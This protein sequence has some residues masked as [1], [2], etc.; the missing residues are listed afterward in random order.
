MNAEDV[1]AVLES[2]GWTASVV[3]RADVSDLV[4]VEAGELMKCV[5]GR[6][7]DHPAMRGPKTLGGIYALASLR[8]ITDVGGLAAI[9][10]EVRAA[11]YGPSVHGDEHAEPQSMGCGY[12][13]LW[14][15]GALDGLE[16]PSF[17]SEQGRD[18]VRAAGG[19]YE[20]L[21]GKHAEQVVMINLVPKMTL[22]PDPSQRFVVDAWIADEFELDI[23][24]YLTLAAQTVELLNGPRIARII[25]P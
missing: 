15:Q 8:G 22:E 1:K 6:P 25:A 13:K 3:R 12:F 16:K 17:D 10:D 14:S 5:D 7:S 23:G 21:T 24:R 20:V 4:D 9:V 18:A 11:G 2:R 19:V